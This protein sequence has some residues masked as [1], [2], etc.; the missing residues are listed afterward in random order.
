MLLLW[1]DGVLLYTEMLFWF[2]VA[3]PG[4]LLYPVGFYLSGAGFGLLFWGVCV[5]LIAGLSEF[6]HGNVLL[7]FC[8]VVLDIPCVPGVP[9]RF[10]FTRLVKCCC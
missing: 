3:Y 2:S 9:A 1:L 4:R 6:G 8:I 5:L 10:R 7:F